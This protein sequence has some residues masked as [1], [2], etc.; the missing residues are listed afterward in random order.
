MAMTP[1]ERKIELMRREVTM[2]AIARQLGV[3]KAHVSQVVAGLRRSP[4][5][6]RAVAEAIG[7]PRA[8]VFPASAA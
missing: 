6:E 4:N 1:L 8:R 7:R 5:V 2:A 3:S